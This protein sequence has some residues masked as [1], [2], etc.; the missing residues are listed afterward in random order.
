MKVAR[1][2]GAAVALVAM[3][4]PASAVCAICNSSVRF[5]AALAACFAKRVDTEL[6]RVSRSSMG[7]VIVNLSDCPKPETRQALPTLTRAPPAPLDSSFVADRTA[8]KCLGDAIAA[9]QGPMDPSVVFELAE[10]CT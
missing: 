10:I 2:V 9:H 3:S 1:L 8:L 7:F 6:D 5:D 4:G